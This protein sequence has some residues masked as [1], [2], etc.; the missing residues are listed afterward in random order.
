MSKSEKYR[1]IGST[2]TFWGHYLIVGLY[3]FVT[4]IGCQHYGYGAHQVEKV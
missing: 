3:H 2:Y 1:V 4:P